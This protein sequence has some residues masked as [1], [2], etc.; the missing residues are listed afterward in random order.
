MEPVLLPTGKSMLNED[1]TLCAK[2]SD[3]CPEE[4][5]KKSILEIAGEVK[6]G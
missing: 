2:G 4:G 1:M 6:D 5:V 3:Y